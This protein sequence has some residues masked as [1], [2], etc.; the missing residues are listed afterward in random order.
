MRLTG[1]KR[2]VMRP[3][4]AR[5]LCRESIRCGS[6]HPW[7]QQLYC[8]LLDLDQSLFRHIGK[9]QREVEDALHR[10]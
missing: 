6:L 10:L 8:P 9:N 2:V 3:M 5:K 1:G 7:C 4:S